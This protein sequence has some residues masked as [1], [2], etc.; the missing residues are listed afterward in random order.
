MT[1]FLR[2]LINVFAFIAIF[3]IILVLQNI[4]GFQTMVQVMIAFVTSRVLIIE[5]KDEYDNE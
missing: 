3:I 5:I 4:V 1:K 2:F